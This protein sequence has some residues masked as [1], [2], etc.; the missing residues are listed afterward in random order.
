MR[1]KGQHL[2][3]SAAHEQA[4]VH[5]P[6]HCTAYKE[7]LRAGKETLADRTSKTPLP[8]RLDSSVEGE[9]KQNED[10]NKEISMLQKLFN[11]RNWEVLWKSG[12]KVGAGRWRKRQDAVVAQDVT[13]DSAGGTRTAF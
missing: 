7:T 6:I 10:N 9:H 11:V 4:T 8:Q 12:G 5:V 2:A 1:E 13:P 3:C